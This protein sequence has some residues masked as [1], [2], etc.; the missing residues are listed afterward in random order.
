MCACVPFACVH[1]MSATAAV[2]AVPNFYHLEVKSIDV[3]Y[4]VRLGCASCKDLVNVSASSS[5][6]IWS[7]LFVGHRR[8]RYRDTVFLS[9][10]GHGNA[11]RA[12]ALLQSA[13]PCPKAHVTYLKWQ[14]FKKY[15]TARNMRDQPRPLP[16]AGATGVAEYC[17]SSLTRVLDLM[18]RSSLARSEHLA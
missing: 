12:V 2:C 8:H 7:H 17:S 15:C 6:K 4:M 16:V 1:C 14:P 18:T 10:I 3:G 13:S 5:G 11:K 9:E